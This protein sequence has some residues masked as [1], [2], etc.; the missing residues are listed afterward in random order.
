MLEISIRR[1]VVNLA[2]KLELPLLLFIIILI[3]DLDLAI[4]D[5]HCI[6]Q[7]E[8]QVL[9]IVKDELI[10]F[11]LL[12]VIFNSSLDLLLRETIQYL[13]VLL[14]QLEL[15]FQQVLLFSLDFLIAEEDL[16]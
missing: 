5:I 12:A 4:K 11:V 16:H 3:L 6:F 14:G 8:N 7:L 10:E 9:L 1:Y 15:A 13:I 2:F